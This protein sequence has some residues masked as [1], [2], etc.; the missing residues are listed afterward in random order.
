MVPNGVGG[1][2]PGGLLY[3]LYSHHKNDPN[4]SSKYILTQ[5]RK[6]GKGRLESSL[7]FMESDHLEVNV[8][9]HSEP[10]AN[11]VNK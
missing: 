1:A 7:K 3:S 2:W 4:S 10:Q 5:K 8:I 11:D 9:C 6:G